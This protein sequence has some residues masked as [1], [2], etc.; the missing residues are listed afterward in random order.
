LTPTATL[1]WLDRRPAKIAVEPVVVSSTEKRCGQ[2]TWREVPD[3]RGVPP[4][5]V[6]SAAVCDFQSFGPTALSDDELRDGTAAAL[7]RLVI[8]VG[9]LLAT[10]PA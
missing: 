1:H 5:E 7:R 10:V 8:R 6:R 3:T 9:E 2:S 4:N